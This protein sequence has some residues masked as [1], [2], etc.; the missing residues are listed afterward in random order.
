M[1]NPEKLLTLRHHKNNS[2]AYDVLRR[3]F[4]SKK[5][6]QRLI[7]KLVPLTPGTAVIEARDNSK[8]IKGLLEYSLVD[9]HEPYELYFEIKE[10]IYLPIFEDG[11]ELVDE[12]DLKKISGIE[13]IMNQGKVAIIQ[14]IES[15]SPGNGAGTQMIKQLK[16]DNPQIILAYPTPQSVGFY[17]KQGFRNSGLYSADIE[18]PGV[19]IWTRE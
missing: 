1:E 7:E 2:P 15:Y 16:S 11:T 13:K 6:Y 17:N 3:E 19:Q 4:N 8:S 9:Y 18:G 12:R 10:R 14:A 5:D